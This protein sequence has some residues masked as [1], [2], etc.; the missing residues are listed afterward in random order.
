MSGEKTFKNVGGKINLLD[1]QKKM[2]ANSLADL[3]NVMLMVQKL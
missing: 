3:A 1:R 2:A